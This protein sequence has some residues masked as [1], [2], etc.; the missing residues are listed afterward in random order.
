MRT[1]S[2]QFRFIVGVCVLLGTGV[3]NAAD[4]A[5][6]EAAAQPKIAAAVPKS[7]NE[8]DEKAIRATAEDFVKAFNAADAKAVG[9]LWASDAEYTDES[10]QST[11]VARRSKRNTPT[12]SK[13]IAARR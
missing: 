4:A 6:D 12:C 3:A 11:R 9:A 8:A 13:S 7:D 1:S 10:G 5:P 2:R